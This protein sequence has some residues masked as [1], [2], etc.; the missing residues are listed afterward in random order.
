L[1]NVRQQAPIVNCG[2]ESSGQV[3][4]GLSPPPPI[5]CGSAMAELIKA[6]ARNEMGDEVFI[7]VGGGSGVKDDSSK[8]RV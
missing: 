6:S 3:N 7:L 4:V 2:W 5:T 1:S 8:L